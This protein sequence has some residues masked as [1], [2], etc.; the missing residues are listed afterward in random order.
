MMMKKLI[1]ALAIALPAA[2]L[3]AADNGAVMRDRE[4][5]FKNLKK[6][7][8]IIKSAVQDAG[9]K[10][11]LAD[12]G[13]QII[14]SAKA[15]P[16]FF[17]AGTKD[18]MDTEAKPNIWANFADFEKK[19]ATLAMS[20]EE[21]V[22]AVNAGDMQKVAS[23]F[24]TMGGDC[25]SCHKEYRERYLLPAGMRGREKYIPAE[26]KVIYYRSFFTEF[27]RNRRQIGSLVPSSRFLA[28]KMCTGIDFHTARGIIELG[29]GTGVMT[30]ELLRRM[31]SDCRLILIELNPVFCQ[32]LKNEIR[33]SR[34]SIVNM[35]AQTIGDVCAHYGITG[36]VDA[37]VSSLPLA[38]IPEAEA[39][40]I[41]AAVQNA[42][43]SGGKYIQYQYSLKSK[44]GIR[45]FFSELRIKFCAANIPPA[46][47]Y[48]ASNNKSV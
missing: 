27:V 36:R 1:L 10:Q 46:F 4:A 5:N 12:A 20:A 13:S 25:K 19:A 7:M 16:G 24:Q 35:P 3:F 38:V 14:K 44:A 48:V 28:K 30:R 42:L 23:G 45:R 22:N 26:R 6:Q 29:P 33:D 39:D 9:K 32:L 2:V 34:V 21:F 11:Q 37:V 31:H 40:D 43:S 15:I 8:D 17:P 47:I 18:E 41:F